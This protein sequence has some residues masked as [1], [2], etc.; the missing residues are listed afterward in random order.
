MPTITL[1]SNND[2]YTSLRD[3]DDVYALAGDDILTGNTPGAILRGGTGDDTYFI[4]SVGIIVFELNGEGS[5]EVRTILRSYTMPDSI[6][7]IAAV[8]GGGVVF[9]GNSLNNRMFGDSG[10]DVLYG[11]VGNDYLDGESDDDTLYGGQG[12]D[13]YASFV[14]ADT[15]VERPFEGIDT[16]VTIISGFRLPENVENLRSIS[17]SGLALFGNSIANSLVGG[18]SDDQLY[19]A[20]GNDY[21]FGGDSQ[22]SGA[23]FFHGGFGF[24]TVSYNNVAGSVSVALDGSIASSGSATGDTFFSIEA[25]TGTPLGDD[26]LRGNELGNLLIGNGGNDFLVGNAGHDQIVGGSGIDVISGNT[27][28]DVLWGGQGQDFIWTGGGQDTIY[29]WDVSASSPFAR[30]RIVD[31]SHADRIDLSAIDADTADSGNQSFRFIGVQQFSGVAGQLRYQR[32]DDPFNTKDATI[33]S[34]DVN[35]DRIADFQVEIRRLIW[36]EQSDFIL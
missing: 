10:K 9:Q 1:T 4:N 34:A 36:I 5:D 26:L 2:N 32:Y 33:I 14:G 24:D 15:I 22:N 20:Q 12:N 11:L 7:E 8:I 28:D 19:G 18:A 23:D 29:Y 25:L 35:G 30:D 16:V 17:D 21:L 31:F 3:N 6:E 27:G 13:T